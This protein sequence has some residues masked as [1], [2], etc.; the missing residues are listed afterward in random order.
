MVIGSIYPAFVVFSFSVREAQPALSLR[1]TVPYVRSLSTT[2]EAPRHKLT[3]T[4]LAPETTTQVSGR[5]G[6]LALLLLDGKKDTL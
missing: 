5:P 3:S 4:V 1:S 6:S 2:P